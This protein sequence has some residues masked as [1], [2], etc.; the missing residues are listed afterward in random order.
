MADWRG[1]AADHGAPSPKPA[2][3]PASKGSG[4]LQGLTGALTPLAPSPAKAYNPWTDSP[5]AKGWSP[6][7]N[8][9]GK[10]FADV[11]NEVTAPS[12]PQPEYYTGTS[13]DF[14]REEMQR[15]QGTDS[16]AY[17]V[18]PVAVQDAGTFAKAMEQEV[19]KTEAADKPKDFNTGAQAYDDYKV[20][21]LSQEEWAKLS[22]S[23]QRVVV[24]NQLLFEASKASPED[25]KAIYDYLGV[26]ENQ[27]GTTH[28]FA[29][30]DDIMD[31]SGKGR[32]DISI[33]NPASAA[34][35]SDRTDV[36][37]NLRALAARIAPGG[38]SSIPGELN[39]DTV[40]PDNF[41]QFLGRGLSYETQRALDDL[42]TNFLGKMAHLDIVGLQGNESALAEF[43]ARFGEAV[44]GLPLDEVA[45]RFKTIADAAAAEDG[46]IDV[47]AM[48]N[49]YGLGGGNG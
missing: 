4:F 21:P 47:E 16:G 40:V 34:G 30:I 13:A 44:K 46:S 2:S 11:Q 38:G 25:A 41:D 1:I 8:G 35:L 39:L 28:N 19:R 12:A 31:V 42:E 37:K 27:R 18:A 45:A 5:E 32:T 24:A 15:D 3:K 9:V 49:F 48:M 43:N 10:F 23:Q 7:V 17:A 20:V 22:P 36:L 33:L 26:G 6:L 14:M 29:T